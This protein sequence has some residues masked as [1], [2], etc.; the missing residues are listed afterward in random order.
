MKLKLHTD[1]DLLKVGKPIELLIPF[2]GLSD[3]EDEPGAMK[4][5]RFNEYMEVGAS[6]F[7]L[8]PIEHCDV[9]VL[10]I[11]YDVLEDQR[12]F[13]R[14]IAPFIKK[15]EAHGKKILIFVGHDV[16]DIRIPVKNAII[17]NSAID[18]SKQP[19]N[20]FPWPHFFEDF[21]KRYNA[22]DLRIRRKHSKPIV[23]FC[24]YAPPLHVRMGKEKIIGL[25][26]LAANYLGLLQRF[27][28]RIAHSYRARAIIGLMRSTRVIPNFRLKSNFAFGP[29]GMNSGNTEESDFDFRKG[30]VENI[31]ESDYTLC[32]RGL[33]NNSIRF[34]E[35]LCCGRI[36][37]FVNTDCVL[38]FEDVIDWKSLCV[39]VEEKNIDNVADAVVRFHAQISEEDFIDLQ[40]KLRNIWE[41]YLSPVGFFKHL[42]SYV[43]RAYEAANSD[44]LSE[45]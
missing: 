26:K 6:L 3:K 10:P 38:P 45:A 24:G 9:C 11:F 14:K 5:G 34:F 39:W 44:S 20:V 23:G 29:N 30:F 4:Y 28:N 21:L 31:L 7:E 1:L 18:K 22:G 36:P 40:K 32:V 17:F 2:T 25:V 15:V 35:T 16:L 19:A 33:G 43:D 8:A 12:E 42:D 27:P 13:E 37:V 41:E